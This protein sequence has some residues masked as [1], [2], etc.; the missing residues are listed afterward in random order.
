[1]NPLDKTFVAYECDEREVESSISTLNP[2]KGVGPNSLPSKILFLLKNEIS[3]PLSIIFNISLNTGTFPNLLKLSETIPIFKKG[4]KMETCNYRPISLLSNIN[5]IFE[6]IM[7]SR[8]YKFLENNKCIY[9]L[10]F[11]FRSKHSTT[12]ALIEITEKIRNALDDN[13]IAC[14]IFI[15]LQKAFDTVNHNILLSKLEYYGVRGIAN[16][17]FKSYLTKRMQYVTEQLNKN[18][19]FTHI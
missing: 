14:G 11:G 15:D 1:M 16:S 8:L 5:K 3:Y 17:W 18:N 4:S 19:F 6:K 13:E 12:H 9:N 10:Q 2:R 7:Y